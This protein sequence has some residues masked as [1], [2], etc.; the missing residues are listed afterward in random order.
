MKL[1]ITQRL[2]SALDRL[3]K[4]P[5]KQQRLFGL[6]T[7]VIPSLFHQVE[8]G[9]VNI[10]LFR[11]CDR[12][13]RCRVKQWLNLPSDTPNAYFH[14]NVK[15]GGLGMASLRWVAPLRRLQRLNKLPLAGT[16]SQNV[17][18]A[19]LQDEI[20][21][22]KERLLDNGQLI[23]TDGKLRERWAQ[24]LYGK[25]D[26]GGLRESAKVPQQHVWVQDGTRLLFGHDYLQACKLRINALPT[27][28]RR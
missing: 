2:V 15:D 3:T 8:L 5:L 11:K 14:A 7:M 16:M 25:V 12:I 26:G 27:K 6:R 20:R 10:S 19:F 4:A 21:K 24:L 18:G 23:S 28:S 22:C 9:N 13:L 17:P 1:D